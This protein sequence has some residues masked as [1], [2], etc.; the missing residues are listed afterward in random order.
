MISYG[1]RNNRFS[2]DDFTSPPQINAPIYAWFWN[3]PVSHE[4]TDRQ[5]EEMKRLGIKFFYIVPEPKNFRP[6]TIPTL[7]EPDYLTPSFFEEYKYAIDRANELGMSAWLYDEGGWPSGGACGKVMLKNPDLARRSLDTHKVTLGANEAYT[8]SDGTLAAFV[9]GDVRVNPGDT[10]NSETEITEYYIANIAYT[11]MWR[12]HAEL[13]DVTQREAIDTFIELT[14]EGYKPYLKEHFGNMMTAVF[15]DEPAAPTKLMRQDLA[16][17]YEKRTGRS[18]LPYL[19]YL[20]GDAE[21]PDDAVEAVCDW[22]D[23]LSEEFCNN[24]LNVEREWCNSNGLLFTGHMNIDDTP[25]SPIRGGNFHVMRALRCFDIPGVDVIWRQIFPCEKKSI[26]GREMGTNHFFPRFAASAAAQVGS[27]YAMTESFGVYGMGLTFD[28]MRW[29]LTFQAIRGINLF[30]MMLIPYGRSG[31]LMTGELPALCEHQACYGDL[32]AFNPYLERLSYIASLGERVCDVALYY[33]IR[34]FWRRG[35]HAVDTENIF[36]K[37]GFA[38]EAA[39][40]NF[41]VID[42]DIIRTADISDTVKIGTAQYKTVI[43]DTAFDIPED[44]MK[45]L[46]AFKVAGGKVITADEIPAITPPVKFIGSSEKIMTMERK[47]DN[48]SLLLVSNENLTPVTV[49]IDTE[50]KHYRL[51]ELTDGTVTDCGDTV[52]LYLEPGELVALLD[53]SDALELSETTDYTH[54]IIFAD[55]TFRREKRMR[56]GKMT[57]E[58][59]LFDE[60]PEPIVL[61]DWRTT[62][63]E[64]YSG[65]CVYK[66][67]FECPEADELQIDLGKVRYTAEVFVNGVSQGVRVMAPYTFKVT[68]PLEETNTLEIRVTNTAA[69]EY[70]FTKSFDKWQDWQIGPY[71]PIS[72]EFDKDS[73]E[74]GLFGPV[75][76]KF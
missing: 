49:N 3:A 70:Y 31:W 37:H 51:L 52:S 17:K 8:P 32:A 15:N 16:E 40:I 69:N 9:R 23:F 5:L 44:V 63:G 20:A 13:P 7:L 42:D 64:D 11:E 4:E 18:I 57:F 2:R 34:D 53:S 61:G 47:L 66:T 22:Y 68:A 14:H 67:T 74:S 26:N 39:H 43:I 46:E 33:P 35:K 12:A 25:N 58:T 71:P 27:R 38:L 60:D 65:S 72:R 41:D 62:V 36:N 6:I 45:R 21:T 1:Q 28:Q 73:L 48:G 30:N 56:I 59:E 75:K 29:V 55:F 24:F 10:F 54:E 50:G 19:P 76:L